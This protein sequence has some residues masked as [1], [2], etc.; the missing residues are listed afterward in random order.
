MVVVEGVSMVAVVGVLMAI[1][2]GVV[3][4]IE[5]EVR[6]FLAGGGFVEEEDD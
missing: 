2:G 1:G 3:L 5:V 6:G 4:M